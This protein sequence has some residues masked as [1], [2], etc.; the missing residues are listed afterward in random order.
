MARAVKAVALLE[1][2]QEREK[3]STDLIARCLYEHVGQGSLLPALQASLDALVGEGLLGYSEKTGYKIESS[4]GQEWQRERD[5]YVPDAEKLSES[6]AGALAELVREADEPALDTLSLP[7]LALFSDDLRSRDVRILDERK[8]TV[9]TVDFQLLKGQRAEQWVPR[10]DTQAYRDR[11]VWV[12]GEVDSVRHAAR[13]LARSARMIDLYDKRQSSLSDDKQR[14]L[15]DERNRRESAREELKEAVAAAFMDGRLYFRGREASPRDAGASFRAALGAFGNRVAAELYPHPATFSVTEKDILYL[16]ENAELAAPPPVLGQEKLGIL[17]MDAGRFEVTCN[18]RI[19]NDLLGYVREH[20]G[21]TGS[22]LLA[23]FGGPPHGVPPDVLRA[24]VVGLLRGGKLRVELSGIGEI[25]SV[26]DEG[27]RELLKDGGLRKAKLTENTVESLGP[28]DRNA[29]CALFRD[30]LGKDLARDN[31][32]IADAVAEKFTVVRERLTALGERFRRLPM[33]TEYPEAL[34][35]L[36]RALET[37]RRDRRVE[38]TAL[39]VKRSLPA[40]R[41]GLTL[42]RR[43]ETDL[44]DAAIAVLRDAEAVRDHVWP[45][46]AAVGAS[47]AASEAARAIVAHLETERPWEEANELSARLEG[48]REEYRAKRRAVLEGHAAAVDEAIDRLKRR[49]GFERL[50]PDERHAVL[51]HLREGAAAS[52]DER[53]T[54]PPLEVLEALLAARRESAEA[55]AAAELD[56]LLEG[57]GERPVVEVALTLGGREI[58]SEAELERV[59]EEIRRRILHEIAAGHRVRV[60]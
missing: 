58:G 10:S 25:T 36:E 12:V 7:W 23:H 24:A 60:R 35:K 3:T 5:G 16:I 49:S 55:K 50:G 51:R 40:L 47:E 30:L 37:C 6:I 1:L 41:D 44:T 43:M 31:E 11:I 34:T 27:A 13:K 20:G 4:A 14:L 59:I 53:A 17:A 18:G 26:R 45:G 38:P 42:L 57:L 21:I 2:I 54:Q 33:G 32:A 22:T 56:A 46:L 52:T 15:I 9:I 29:I 39:A 19:P 28:R 8:H 48:V